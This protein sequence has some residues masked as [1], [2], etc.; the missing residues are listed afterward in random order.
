[1]TARIVLADGTDLTIP[2]RVECHVDDGVF[3]TRART[4][5]WRA[6]RLRL[7]DPTR[8]NL[9]DLDPDASG[10]KLDGSSSA[11][12]H[13]RRRAQ[14][15]PG[16]GG[17]GDPA[18]PR[19][20]GRSQRAGS[21]AEDPP[22]RA[23]DPPANCPGDAP[24]L[25]TEDVNKG[26]RVEVWDE[27]AERGFPPSALER[28]RAG[29]GCRSPWRRK[30]VSC[31]APAS[32]TPKDKVAPGTAPKTYLGE[33]L[34]GWSGW[35]LSAPHPARPSAFRYDGHGAMGRTERDLR[36]TPPR[37]PSPEVLSDPRVAPGTLPRLRYGRSYAMPWGVDLADNSPPRT[38]S[39]PCP[40]LHR[41]RSRNPPPLPALTGRPPSPSPYAGFVQLLR[42]EAARLDVV[43]VQ[44]TPLDVHAAA[45][46]VTGAAA[47]LFVDEVHGAQL[48][49]LFAGLIDE[50]R[51][52][53]GD[54]P[55]AAAVTDPTTM[56]SLLDGDDS[57]SPPTS[58]RQPGS[59]PSPPQAVGPPSRPTRCRRCGA[60]ALAADRAPGGRARVVPSA[61]ASPSACSSS[62][63]GS[64][65]PTIPTR[66]H[67]H[68]RRSDGVRRPRVGSGS[69]TRD[70]RAPSRTAEGEPTRGR[71]PR[72]VR[73]AIGTTTRRPAGGVARR[74][75]RVRQLPRPSIP[76]LTDPATPITVT[77]WRSPPGPTPTRSVRRPR[78]ARP[79]DPLGPGQ[80]LIADTEPARPSLPPRPPGDR[81]VVAVRRCR[82]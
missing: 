2:T 26:M 5:D 52:R 57:S 48:R 42:G 68:R 13:R 79:G 7:G 31:R 53:T 9:L 82:P 64:T 27:K 66:R 65:S 69:P 49:S 71:V 70:Q 22:V 76:S 67:D 40:C 8:F 55:A 77:T 63:A 62:A 12:P 60:F 6:G 14:R 10:L 3:T 21:G 35:S 37:R 24:L 45:A 46:A 30:K 50:R 73:H 61:T 36:G 18:G 1:M 44:A 47:D 33:T 58:G 34:F 54:A 16:L 32:E 78:H 23:P 72:H 19:L 75:A 56:R 28:A 11:S 41:R 15:R 80:Y 17:S 81:R 74:T 38:T 20:R 4:G 43:S 51:R 25:N 29:H 39:S 59:L